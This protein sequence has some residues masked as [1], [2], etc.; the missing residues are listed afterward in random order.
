E[1]VSGSACD[2]WNQFE[3]DILCL[4]ELGVNSYRFSIEWSRVEPER[5]RF[6]EAV[7]E[8][9]AFFARRL[10]EE[11]IEPF[12]TL[13]HWPVPL[14]VRDQGG[15]M[16][17]QTVEDFVIFSKKIV[18][19]LGDQVVNWIT[20]N[21]PLVYAS[22]SY[23]TG[24]WP[25]Q[26]KSL[27]QTIKVARHLVQAH[28][29]AYDAL[30]EIDS[31]LQVGLSKHNIHFSARQ[32]WGV[33][34][35]VARAST[36]VWNEWFLNR[37]KQ[38]QDFIGLNYYFHNSVDLKFGKKEKI[39]SDLG[40]ELYPE[41]LYRVLKGL[42]R[43]GKPVYIT[44]HGLADKDDR[45]RAWYLEESLRHAHRALNEGVDLRGYF[46][47][48]LLDNF[49]WADG[50]FPRFGLFEVDFATCI[51]KARTSVGVYRQIIEQGGPKMLD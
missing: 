21:E 36:Y 15:W 51:R 28:K 14:W 40:W 25:P 44:E 13:W 35:L 19:A 26:S 17:K 50:F 42:R 43:F 41:G 3:Q 9:Y 2:S 23:L 10:R 24:Q 49:E 45:H 30:K 18:Q 34:Q 27:F 1:Y 11:G 7:I 29:G 16:S 4:K 46:H 5:G 32:P 38:H 39:V 37:V 8:R 20:I 22:N 6:D 47:W 33:N 12:V 48:S 31:A